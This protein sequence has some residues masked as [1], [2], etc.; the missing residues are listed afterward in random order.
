MY[1]APGAV[2][3]LEEEGF[4]G[5]SAESHFQRLKEIARERARHFPYT[6]GDEQQAVTYDVKIKRFVLLRRTL[7]DKWEWVPDEAPSKVGR[8]IRRRK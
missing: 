1:S 6:W 7:D 3:R 2:R 8:N 4:Y 5:K